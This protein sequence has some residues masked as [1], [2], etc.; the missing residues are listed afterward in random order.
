[1]QSTMSLVQQPGLHSSK[2][3]S[4][5]GA[6]QLL[7]SLPARVAVRRAVVPPQAFVR[8]TCGMPFGAGRASQQILEQMLQDAATVGSAAVRDID[9]PLAVDA[10]DEGEEYL[11]FADLPGVQ[12]QDLKVQTK[13][14]KLTI[15]G[16]RDRSSE[17]QRDKK[18]RFERRF[19]RFS[20]QLR[21]PEDADCNSIKAKVDNGVL[22]VRIGKFTKLPG[23]EDVPIDF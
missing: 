23:V 7:S 9:L 6:Q 1:M 17:P 12:R 19:G 18:Q 8:G 2:L 20:R 3:N 13:D 22:A 11:F 16:K 21:L 10:V 15:S 5:S 4:R 14:N